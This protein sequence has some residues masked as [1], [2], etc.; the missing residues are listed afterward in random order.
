M[1][2]TNGRCTCITNLVQ[3]VINKYNS[4]M[5]SM[6]AFRLSPHVVLLLLLILQVVLCDIKINTVQM[7]SGI[8]DVS[9]RSF[10]AHSKWLSCNWQISV[11]S[12]PPPPPPLTFFFFLCSS[13]CPCGFSL[14]AC[15]LRL[16]CC[17][18]MLPGQRC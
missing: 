8:T 18:C 9:F 2:I 17:L 6:H 10:P 7:K 16:M 1:H 15:L 14:P 13:L 12:S 11:F 3:P 4:I 5:L